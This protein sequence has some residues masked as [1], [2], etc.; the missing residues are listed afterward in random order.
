MIA[1][2]KTLS[3]EEKKIRKEEAN[4]FEKLAEPPHVVDSLQHLIGLMNRSKEADTTISA[5]GE[6]GGMEDIIPEDEGNH[7]K[8][9]V[10]AERTSSTPTRKRQIE[11]TH[12][13]A[14]NS[15]SDEKLR[16]RRVAK[17]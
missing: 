16:R 14:D 6:R 5:E 7:V 2:N 17:S 9:E 1:S 15:N 11:E 12:E 13:G 10:K 8:L 4:L 3:D